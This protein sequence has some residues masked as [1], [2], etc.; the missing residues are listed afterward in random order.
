MVLKKGQM[1]ASFFFNYLTLN[2][3][4]SAVKVNKISNTFLLIINIYLLN[5][6][7]KCKKGLKCVT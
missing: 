5:K 2:T 6:V 1:F 4:K 7:I 3:A